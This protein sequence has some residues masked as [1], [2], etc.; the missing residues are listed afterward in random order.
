[1]LVRIP[2]LPFRELILSLVFITTTQCQR[3]RRR[4][5]ASRVRAGVVDQATLTYRNTS[6]PVQRVRDKWPCEEES[7]AT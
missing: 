5:K 6:S 7:G 3:W 4:Q 1:M 2:P